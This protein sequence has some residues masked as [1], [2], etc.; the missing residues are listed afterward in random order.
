MNQRE[1]LKK[2]Y[3]ETY[4]NPSKAKL[5]HF[6]ILLFGVFLALFSFNDSLW[7]I[8]LIT[9]VLTWIAFLIGDQFLYKKEK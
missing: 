3:L 1:A 5:V 6:S 2:S 7:L 4:E 8:V 9:P